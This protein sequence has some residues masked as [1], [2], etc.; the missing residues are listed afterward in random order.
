MNR[1]TFIVAF[2]LAAVFL[3][4]AAI[5]FYTKGMEYVYV[6]SADKIVN[7]ES[8][9]NQGVR[10]TAQEV[11]T[12]G[13]IK[14]GNEMFFSDIMGLYNGPLTI[15]NIGKVIAKFSGKGTT[16]LQVEAAQSFTVGNV[17][18]QKGELIDTGLDVP[19]GAYAP[20][21]IRFT[22]SEGKVKAGISC[23]VCHAGKYFTNNQVIPSAVIKTEPSRAHGGS[24]GGYKASSLFGLY[25]SA[26]HLHDGGVSWK[27]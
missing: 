22:V 24:V 26:P 2:T 18:I 23:L 15:P 17:V 27:G 13:M 14:F 3:G 4:G 12:P 7:P 11:V 6:P 5:L 10:I 16:N 19:K 9:H 25:W 1:R 21:G 20:L 8:I